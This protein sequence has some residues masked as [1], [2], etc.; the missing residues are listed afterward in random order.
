MNSL[1]PKLKRASPTILSCMAAVGTIATAIMA[2]KATP[3]A[4]ELCGDLQ[5][6]HFEQGKEEPTK[7]EYVKAAW[8][9]YIPSMAIGLGTIVCILGANGL[10]RKQQTALTSAYILLENGFKEYKAK[11]KELYGEEAEDRV[12]NAIAK[13]QHR[14]DYE[15][16]DGKM[17]FYD[18]YSC[19]Y[20]E[21]R[22]EEVIDAE[23]QLNRKFALED[24]VSLNDLYELLGLETIDAGDAVGWSIGAG[25]NFYNYQWIDFEH[26]LATLDDGLECYIF[27]TVCPP[28]ADFMD[29][30]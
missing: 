8:K 26:E 14:D 21:R 18:E 5:L 2:V 12:R 16:T 1:M 6:D 4:L 10:N 15:A 13:D 23:Y 27:H 28:T 22:M 19:R 20:F 29:Y 25:V 11:V 3:K 17:L 7:L 9:P 30:C 24:Y